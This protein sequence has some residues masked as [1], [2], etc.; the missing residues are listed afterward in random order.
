MYLNN[1]LVKEVDGLVDV[2]FKK[3]TQQALQARIDPAVQ[4][5]R[6]P[7]TEAENAKDEKAIEGAGFVSERSE[8][9][10]LIM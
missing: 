4:R 1:I 2:Y 3:G 10:A 6:I 5:F 8:R 9:V 7:Y